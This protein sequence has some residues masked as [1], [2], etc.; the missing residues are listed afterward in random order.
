MTTLIEIIN[1]ELN[2]KKEL[3]SDV[4]GVTVNV[5]LLEDNQLGAT[6]T[7]DCLNLNALSYYNDWLI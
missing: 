3:I 6:K 4:N 7:F 5:W 2:M 1:T